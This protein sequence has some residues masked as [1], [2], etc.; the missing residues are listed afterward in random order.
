MVIRSIA[1]ILA[2]VAAVDPAAGTKASIHPMDT[3]EGITFSDGDPQVVHEGPAGEAVIRL[4]GRN[5][6]SAPRRTDAAFAAQINLDGLDLDAFDVLKIEVSAAR[7]AVILLSLDNYP[8]VGMQAR[9]YI[10]DGIRGPTGW[11]TIIV[12]LRLPEEIRSSDGSSESRLLLSGHVRDSG[13][14]IQG[15]DRRILLGAIRA[16]DKAVDVDW[17]QRAFSATMQGADLVYAYPLRVENTHSAPITADLRMGP[18]RASRARATVTPARLTLAPG[19]RAVAEVRIVLPDAANFQPLYTERFEVWARAEGIPDSDV[20]LTRSSDVIHLPVVVPLPESD[21][22]FP[23]LPTP[24][25]LPAHVLHFDLNLAQSRAMAQPTAALIAYARENGIYNYRDPKDDAGF[26]SALISAAYLYKLTGQSQFLTVAR[27][28]IRALPGIWAEQSRQYEERVRHQLISSGIIVRMGEGWHYTLG[29]GWRLA[30]TQRS[31]YYYGTSGNGRGGGMS[32]IFYAFDMIAPSLTEKERNSF[33]YDFAVP[34]GIRVRNHYFGDGNQ[35]STA[36]GAA[37]Y[38]GLI[39][40]NWPLVAFATNSEHGTAS[41]LEWTYS[42]DGLH[43]RDGYQ[44]YSLRPI[45][46]NFELLHHLG[47]NPYETYR[48]RLRTAVDWRGPRGFEDR[49]FWDFVMSNRLGAPGE[50]VAPDDLIARADGRSRISL[51]WSDASDNEAWFLVERR[52]ASERNFVEVG[53]S[54]GGWSAYVDA[55][56]EAGVS[57]EYRVHAVNYASGKSGFSNLATI[58]CD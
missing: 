1:T 25:Q 42:D 18:F 34:A 21:L 41:V 39:A 44:T 37:L 8:E 49:Y 20:T 56:P 29:L 24:D 36:N 13:R 9:W 14:T 58:S 7:G 26:R 43:V 30:G 47:L 3:L 38:A 5:S 22:Q 40:R 27:E 4:E 33:I 10:L 15:E 19:E 50:I 31:P 53:R 2:F 32:A 12:D 54:P 46:F 51:S 28:L 45:F 48:S 52:S 17:D 11:R 55:C 35:Q 16:V 6:S 23:L 57:Y